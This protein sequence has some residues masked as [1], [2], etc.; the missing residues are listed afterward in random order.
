MF[1]LHSAQR[2]VPELCSPLLSAHL[3][4]APKPCYQRLPVVGWR[5]QTAVLT[6]A[7]YNNGVTLAFRG[8]LAK[9]LASSS[10]HDRTH[11]CTQQTTTNSAP[12]RK[13]DCSIIIHIYVLGF[14]SQPV[15]SLSS[16]SSLISGCCSR[17]ATLP[18]C[19]E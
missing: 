17:L 6:A 2:M 10:Q 18:A 7:P 13:N 11:E 5:I 15:L 12:K 16:S 4:L 9:V 14:Y 8:Y 3:P 1:P 19:I